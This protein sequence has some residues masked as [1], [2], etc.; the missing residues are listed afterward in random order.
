MSED[1]KIT[2]DDLV[3]QSASRETQ[4]SLQQVRQDLE[5]R[6]TQLQGQHA[7]AMKEAQ[8]QKQEEIDVVR[9]QAEESL[10]QAAQE[11]Q[12]ALEILEKKYTHQIDQLQS[13]KGAEIAAPRQKTTGRIQRVNKQ[14]RQKFEAKLAALRSQYA[15]AMKRAELEK[16]AEPKRAKAAQ[17][18]QQ[19]LSLLKR[20][21]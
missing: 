20:E 7:D 11:H 3:K 17:D 10:I 1:K 5:S 14:T 13:G 8:R 19:T 6:I 4:Q 12:K 18:H 9:K 2:F 16:S 15:D 21:P